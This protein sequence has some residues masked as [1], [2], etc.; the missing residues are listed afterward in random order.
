[1]EMTFLMEAGS[2]VPRVFKHRLVPDHKVELLA[3]LRSYSLPLTDNHWA[4]RQEVQGIKGAKNKGWAKRQV[5][6]IAG[7]GIALKI[8]N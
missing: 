2:I 4:L 6:A 3:A 8:C 5:N 7:M 1:M